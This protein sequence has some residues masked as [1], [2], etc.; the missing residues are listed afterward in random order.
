MRYLS[1]ILGLLAALLLAA[2]GNK[3]DKFVGYWQLEEDKDQV[4]IVRKVDNNTYTFNHIYKDKKG[5][6]GSVLT[7]MENGDF[8][9]PENKARAVMSED[10]KTFRV[11]SQIWYRITEQ[12][13]EEELKRI[14]AILAQAKKDREA[15][16][17]LLN[18]YKQ[19]R[20]KF[21]TIIDT[22]NTLDYFKRKEE[23]DKKK[24]AL[25]EQYRQKASKIT[26]CADTFF[27]NHG[28]G[29]RP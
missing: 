8:E 14:E 16:Q 2:C 20:Q 29:I 24:H 4:W 15:C 17:S 9:Y 10:G 3:H 12:Q 28:I 27:I 6:Q 13:A 19:Q 18:E 1:V 26:D 11:G 25:Y 22:G 23:Q 7:K 5:M 21:I